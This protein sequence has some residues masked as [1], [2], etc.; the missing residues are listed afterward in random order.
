MGIGDAGPV[1]CQW[2]WESLDEL[3]E[4]LEFSIAAEIEKILLIVAIAFPLLLLHNVDYISE[5]F[6]HW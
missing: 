3:F 1:E 2:I 6:I 5:C 4:L